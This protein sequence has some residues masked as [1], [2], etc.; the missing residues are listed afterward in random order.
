M[1]KMVKLDDGEQVTIGDLI[2][3][4][5]ITSTAHKATKKDKKENIIGICADTYE[6]NEILVC[7]EGILEV[8]V[9]GLIC[10]GDHLTLSDIPGKLEAIKYTMQD[11]EQFG[12]M[13][14]GKVVALSDKYSKAKILIGIK[15]NDLEEIQ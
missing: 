4:S 8:N 3:F 9:N 1:S 6:D 7:D 14:I 15:L 11:E 12:I 13:R 2:A 5:H 10:L